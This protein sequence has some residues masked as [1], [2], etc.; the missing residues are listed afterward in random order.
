MSVKIFDCEPLFRALD[1]RDA[2]QWAQQMR[3]SCQERFG[4]QTHGNFS[5]WLDAWQNL[6]APNDSKV[7]IVNGKVTVSGNLPGN[8]DDVTAALMQL[9][10]WRKGPFDFQG[11]SIDTEWRSDWKWER[12]SGAIDLRR[13]AVLDIGCGNGYYGWRMIDEGAELVVGLDPMLLYVMQFEAFRRYSQQQNHFVIPGTDADLP[14][15]LHAFDTTFSMGVL[16]HR[17]SPID[18]LQSLWHSLRRGGDLVL[19]TLIVDSPKEEVLV[20]EG[21]YA[22]MRNVWFLPSVPMLLRWLHRTG[23][24]NAQVIDVSKTTTSE[25]RTTAWMKFNS[26]ADFLDADD[27][28]KTI[29]G[30][31]AP[32]RAVIVAQR[33]D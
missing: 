1:Q 23:F 21:R 27:S 16:Y 32:M 5:T 20:P 29:E 13:R 18:H 31:P 25:Q 8:A 12:I 11:I 30:Y 33:G 22:Q 15:K 17:T 14:E 9:H 26:L 6:P 3:T 4:K 19:E 2:T 7:D 28:T 24:R 10:P